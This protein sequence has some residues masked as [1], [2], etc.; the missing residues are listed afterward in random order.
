MLKRATAIL[1]LIASPLLIGNLYAQTVTTVKA[2]NALPQAQIDQLMGLGTA[3]T[4]NDVSSGTC[5]GL[6]YDNT[7]CGQ[8]VQFTAVVM[9][10][11][12][13]SGLA[14]ANNGVPGR[15]HVFVRDVTADTDGPEGHGIQVVDGS[16]LGFDSL[17]KGDVIEIVGSVGH[18]GTTLQ[19]APSSFTVV[20]SRD[21]ASDAI[22]NPIVVTSSDVNQDMGPD[23]A[24]QVN[25]ANL[26]N[27]RGNFVQMQNATLLTRTVAPGGRPDYNVTSDGGTTSVSGYDTSLRYRN[28]RAGSYPATFNVRSSDF[29][30]PAPG[31]KVNI[32]GFLTING[33]TSSDPFSLGVPNGMVVAINPFDDAD[34][35][36]TETPPAISGVS[37]PSGVPGNAPIDITADVEIDVTRTLASAVIKYFTTSDATVMEVASSS[38]AGNTHTFQ[39]PAVTDGDFVTFWVVAEDNTGAV[40]QSGQ[41]STRALYGGITSI[42]HIQQTADNT[43]GSSPFD[44]VTT[45]MNLNATVQYSVPETGQ[46]I[47]QDDASG[48]AWSGIVVRGQT[49]TGTLNA[50]DVVN[51]TNAL[52]QES[53]GLTRIRDITFTVVS[54]GG[55]TIA[56]VSVTTSVLADRDL[57]EGFEGVVVEIDDPVVTSTNADAPSGPFGELLISSDGT[58]A[59]AIRV[60]DASSAVSYTGGDPG[61]VYSVGQRLDF[62][63]GYVNYSFSNFKLEPATFD[64]IGQVINVANEEDGL[65]IEFT[66]H[67]N[68]PNPFN[69]STQIQFDAAETGHV[70]LEVFDM[71]GRKVATLI[72]GVVSAGQ[73]SVSFDASGLT[74]GLYVYRLSSGSSVASRKMLLLR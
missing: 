38:Q 31:A 33:G 11:P 42:A 36:I 73:H 30:P 64:D 48:A 27:I 8:S 41:A 46:V 62:V 37:R 29:T 60:D 34:I 5:T 56:P 63:R 3:L 1:T 12:L 40:S 74:S 28:D 6:L 54:T 18:F 52:I 68:Y 22:F 53:F 59:N 70:N 45:D 39:I 17:V 50:G 15:I 7:L 61:T 23:G 32:Q 71:L 43:Q 57:A 20:G 26:P 69:P 66:L 14:S 24:I 49:E 44:G 16:G 67:Q 35:Q 19:I 2:I 13:S 21:P 9:T 51:V 4:G 58:G 47:L 72:G 65:P 55:S 25:W 10:D